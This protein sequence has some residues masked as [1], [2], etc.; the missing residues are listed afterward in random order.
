MLVCHCNA[1]TDH[2][3]RSAVDWMRASDPETVITPGKV[4]RALGKR[5]DCGGCLPVFL[6]TMENCDSF[7]VPMQ[8]RGLRRAPT[9]G[10]QDEGR[11]QSNR[12]SQRRAQ[13]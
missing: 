4:Y 11:H 1:I 6:A 7:E 10:T 9:Q 5:P 3:I 2:E 13:K 12:V 8:L